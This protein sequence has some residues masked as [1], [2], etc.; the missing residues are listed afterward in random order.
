M[1][2]RKIGYALFGVYGLVMLWLLFG[3]RWGQN[4]G[5]LN[6]QIFDTIRRYFWV[7]RNSTDP[8]LRR[9]A[10]VNLAG[11]VVMFVPLG[12]FGPW[13]FPRLRKFG[14]HILAMLAVIVAV[15]LLQWLTGLGTCDV[16]DLLLNLPGTCLGFLLWKWPARRWLE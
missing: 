7:L 16:D 10:W 5:A 1:N 13:L 6:W 11:N 12:F 8:E 15:E 4:A 9:H 3:Q 2:R 14:I